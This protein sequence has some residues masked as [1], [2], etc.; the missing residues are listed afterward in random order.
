[1]SAVQTV[2]RPYARRFVEWAR[3]RDEVLCLS[4]DL[5]GSCEVDD[6]RDAYPDRFVSLGMAEQN[7][8]GVAGGL[9]REGFV[10]FV[11]TFS[12][13]VTRRPYDQVG[14]AIAYPN[15]PVRLMGFL[16]GLTTPGG[17]THQAIDDVALMRALPNMTVLDCGDATDV[18]TVLEATEQVD[19]PLFC[20]VLRGEVPRLFSGPMRLGQAR[21]L[22]R[23]TDVC[24]LSSGICTEEAMRAVARI[25]Q[26]GVS[27]ALLHVS[28]LKP[29]ADPS[30][31]EAIAACRHGVVT[32]EN[33]SVVGGLGS[34]VAE[35]MAEAGLGGRLVRLGLQ[36]TYAH[37]GSRA[38]LLDYYGLSARHLVAKVEALLGEPLGIEPESLREVEL[39]PAAAEAKAEAL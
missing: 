8:M 19:G 1:V 26:R 24:V 30:V 11:H 39:A 3:E 6:F 34:A 22:S 35:A 9:A 7:L 32:M 17:V 16:P 33:H 4:A 14:M 36:D 10:P 15:L 21:V 37:G 25:V 23:G 38:Y 27:V 29:F 13:F 31:R 12:V 5:T 2:T 20:R 18:E 28:T